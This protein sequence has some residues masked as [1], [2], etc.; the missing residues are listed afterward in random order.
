MLKVLA[1]HGATGAAEKRDVKR[2]QKACEN[3]NTVVVKELIEG[4]AD[5]NKARNNGVTPVNIG[6][7]PT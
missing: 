4:G 3:G 5:V 2:M 6:A 7:R 1:E